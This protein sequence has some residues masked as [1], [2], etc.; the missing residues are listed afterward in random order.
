[1]FN[2]PVQRTFKDSFTWRVISALPFFPLLAWGIYDYYENQGINPNY[3]PVLWGF[4][5]FFGLLFGYACLWAAKKRVTVYAEG[6]SYKSLVN[7][8]DLRWDEITETRYSQQPVNVYMHFGLIGLLFSLAKKSENLV[9]SLEIIGPRKIKLSSNL[10]NVQEAIRL[11][12]AAVNPRLRQEAERLLN[13]GGTVVFANISLCPAGVIWKSKEPIPY[14]ALAKCRIDGGTLRIK[15]EGKW[16]DNIAVSPKRIPNVFIMLDL[17][18]AR[19]AALG[20]QTGA[21]V[22]ASSAGQ[23]V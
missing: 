9:R 2:S 18:E 8:T 3:G 13:S 23:Y 17:I 10:S 6:I 4:I 1:M 5:A 21:A 16:L 22:A 14:T 12:L 20:Q 15:A 19:R 11:V 7:Q